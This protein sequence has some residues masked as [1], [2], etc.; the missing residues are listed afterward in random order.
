MGCINVLTANG[1]E[2]IWNACVLDSESG[3][4]QSPSLIGWSI[5]I[6]F[7]SSVWWSVAGLAVKFARKLKHG[8]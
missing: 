6:L 7:W 1:L 3:G 4:W 5:L 8:N 2:G